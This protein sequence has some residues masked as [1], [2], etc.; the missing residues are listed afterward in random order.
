MPLAIGYLE[1]IVVFGFVT[2]SGRCLQLRDLA[3]LLNLLFGLAVISKPI[4]LPDYGAF[5]LFHCKM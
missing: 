2:L 5:S 4:S 1:R 3:S